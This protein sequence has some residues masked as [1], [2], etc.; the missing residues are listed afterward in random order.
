MGK[1]TKNERF[2]LVNYMP[3]GVVDYWQLLYISRAGLLV[4][5]V[6]RTDG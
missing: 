1:T 5:I 2:F 6:I 3:G 4:E